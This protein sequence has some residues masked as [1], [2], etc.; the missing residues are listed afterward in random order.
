MVGN[1]QFR[2]EAVT[3]AQQAIDN[4][5][6]SSAFMTTTPSQNI[7]INRDGNTDYTVTFTP[8][9]ICKTFQEVDTTQTG[10]PKE[11]YG[12]V[13]GLCYWAIWDVT[14]VISDAKTG[15]SIT[16]HQGIRTITGLNA[17]LISCGV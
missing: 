1:A 2:E 14:A 12:S 13:G 5:I 17:A 7:D 6:S 10:L 3:A 16:L 9:P 15:T 4:V 11:C 8:A